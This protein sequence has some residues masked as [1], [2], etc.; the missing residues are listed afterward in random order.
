MNKQSILNTSI[1]VI[2]A[3]IVSTLSVPIEAANV[4]TQTSELSLYN[5]GMS[6][7]QSSIIENLL[8]QHR[9]YE[10]IDAMEVEMKKK[11][12]NAALLFKEANT[13]ADME[14]FKEAEQTLIKLE[15]LYPQ[16]RDKNFD[17]LESYVKQK[18]SEERKN[19]IGFDQDEAYV[20]DIKHYWTYSSL[21]YYRFTDYGTFGGHLNY[22]NRYGSSEQQ[23]QIEAN[24]VLFKGAYANLMYAY[25]NS[26][27]TLYPQMQ[28]TIEPYFTLSPDFSVSIGQRFIRF[29]G[30]KIYT[31]TGSLGKYSGNYFSWIRWY[32]YTPKSTDYYE[33]NVRRYFSDKNTFITLRAGIGKYPD[34]GD[35]APLNQI[36]ILSANSLRLDGQ[37]PIYRDLFLKGGVGFSK[38][39][40]PSG[41]IRDIT[42]ASLGI[43]WQF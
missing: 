3:A 25:A 19:E 29:Q 18:R 11:P 16:L 1:C 6:Q 35:V 30:T 32:H 23:Y 12:D 27:Q 39:Y 13:Y 43:A 40:F 5:D 7:A 21:H 36:L 33:F 2:F 14:K 26:S 8:V 9:F 41:T 31:Y 42:D 28:Y 34:I 37:L 22:A 10:A 24:P 38:Q 20:S 17:K 4:N 15:T